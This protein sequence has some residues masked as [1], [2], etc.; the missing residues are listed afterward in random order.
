MTS[1]R[2]ADGA[3]PGSPEYDAMPYAYMTDVNEITTI[4]GSVTE[5]P[6]MDFAIKN[7]STTNSQG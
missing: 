3:Q 4:D 5:E 1:T 2:D 7:E 6:L